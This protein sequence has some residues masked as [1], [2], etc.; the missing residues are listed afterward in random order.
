MTE[1]VSLDAVVAAR[2]PDGPAHP[3]GSS[4][5]AVERR[6]LKAALLYADTVEILPLSFYLLTWY[7][8]PDG[9]EFLVD[10]TRPISEQNPEFIWLMRELL[11]WPEGE[12][13]GETEL[14]ADQTRRAAA[15]ELT[16]DQTKR[17]AAAYNELRLAAEAQALVYP[18]YS[19]PVH[20]GVELERERAALYDPTRIPVLPARVVE[21]AIARETPK[22]ALEGVLATS[23]LGQLEGFP[24]ASMDVVIDVRERLADSRVYFR[25]AIAEAAAEISAEATS[26]NNVEALVYDLRRRVIDPALQRLRDEIELLAV[27]RTLLR[28]ASDRVTLATSAAA[29]SVAAGGLGS[30]DGV[31]ALIHGIVAAPLAAAAAKEADFRVQHKAH[32]RAQPFWLL[33]EADREL[34]TRQRPSRV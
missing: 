10:Y 5:F 9:M 24:D 3:S 18:Y 28:M 16:A 13:H 31:G 26:G 25:A 17:A 32:L 1:P 29:L 14:T 30:F 27:R 15:A 34:R 20:I 8:A 7:M 4:L 19:Q 22:V 23:L 21:A 2:T 12:E 11:E 6:L 33:H